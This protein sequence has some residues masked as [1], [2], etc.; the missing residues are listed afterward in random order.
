MQPDQEA[1]E[2]IKKGTIKKTPDLTRKLKNS[3]TSSIPSNNKDPQKEGKKSLKSI[4]TCKSTR[5]N[6]PKKRAAHM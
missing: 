2:E 1:K 5:T 4:L 6:Q 3:K